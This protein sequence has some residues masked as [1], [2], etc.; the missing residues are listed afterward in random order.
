MNTQESIA[1]LEKKLARLRL[2]VKLEEQL[3]I[4]FPQPRMCARCN[5]IRDSQH[6]SVIFTGGNGK[7]AARV[8]FHS[9]CNQCRI[10]QKRETARFKKQQ[11]RD[12]FGC[13]Y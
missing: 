8:R 5:K 11:F 3:R 1:F 7:V 6:W 13:Q 12:E 2:R 9:Y 10:E 4:M